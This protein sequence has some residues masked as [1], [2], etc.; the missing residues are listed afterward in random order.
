MKP[1][2]TD[3]IFPDVADPHVYFFLAGLFAD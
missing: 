1:L 3:D 2:A